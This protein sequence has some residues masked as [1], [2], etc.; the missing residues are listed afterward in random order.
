MAS[1]QSTTQRDTA[2]RLQLPAW[3]AIIMQGLIT[4]ALPLVLILINARLLMTKPY[5]IWQY[6]RPNFPEDRYGFTTEDRL[7]YGPV[8]LEYLF[9]PDDDLLAEQTFPDGS[10]LYNER[11]ISHMADVKVVTKQLSVIGYTLI[12]LTLVSV[13]GLSLDDRQRLRLLKAGMNGGV[14]TVFVI[15]GG[16]GGV[17][18]AF[19]WLFTQFHRLFFEGSTWIFPTS[20]TLIRLFPERFWI[21]AFAL[22]FGGALLEGVGIAILSWLQLKR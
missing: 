4:V 1:T 13:A 14:L 12:V 18:L 8:A 7:E 2:S 21:D 6:Y 15:V 9:G 10:P 17:T 20:D 22:V 16:L 19:D 11:E 5:M 3:L